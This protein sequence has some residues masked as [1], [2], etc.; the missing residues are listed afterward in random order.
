[1][2]AVVHHQVI[3]A[4][5]QLRLRPPCHSPARIDE[6]IAKSKEGEPPRTG[7]LNPFDGPLECHDSVISG[8][9]IGGIYRGAEAAVLACEVVFGDPEGA[10]AGLANRDPDIV[11][12][13][14]VHQLLQWRHTYTLD[15]G[16]NV[17]FDPRCGLHHQDDSGL[18]PCLDN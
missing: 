11:V 18:M 15:L 16:S 17:V 12:S 6:I 9:G 1:M 14:E 4:R 13:Q 8:I 10:A 3:A 2:L 5:A 7:S